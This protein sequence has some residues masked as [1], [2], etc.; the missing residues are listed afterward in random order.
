MMYMHH[1]SVQRSPQLFTSS[2]LC[3]LISLCSPT[4]SSRHHWFSCCLHTFACFQYVGM[5]RY[6][7][8]SDWRLSLSSMCLSVLRDLHGLIAHVFLIVVESLG[9]VWL[10]TTSCTAARQASLAFPISW[11]LIKLM[12]IESVMPSNRLILCCPLLLLP[13]IFPSIRVFSNESALHI[14][15][16]SFSFNNFIEI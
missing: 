11:S 7:V 1:H 15:C 13:S 9:C 8:I 4:F 16:W 5:S 6:A 14:R 2:A 12:S 10:F 3:L